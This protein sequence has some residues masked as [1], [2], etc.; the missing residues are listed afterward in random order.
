MVVP[1]TNCF[2]LDEKCETKYEQRCETVDEQ[3][4]SSP[5]DAD[6]QADPGANIDSYGPPQA[7]PCK[8]VQRYIAL[9]FKQKFS[10]ILCSKSLKIGRL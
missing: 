9:F 5:P 2:A 4:C 1:R 10:R 7:P 6:V 8:I 3:D